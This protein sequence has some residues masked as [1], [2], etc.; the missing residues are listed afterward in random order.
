MPPFIR[1]SSFNHW[2]IIFRLEASGRHG[3]YSSEV[4]NALKYAARLPFR[5]GVSKTIILVT[6]DNSGMTFIV[7]R[8][9]HY[10]KSLINLGPIF[11]K[12][13]LVTKLLS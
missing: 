8:P 2:F 5:P 12:C 7:N 6:C 11:K 4:F 13:R 9:Q 1:I 10:I 3:N